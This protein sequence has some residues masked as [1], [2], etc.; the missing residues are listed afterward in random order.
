MTPPPDSLKARREALL[1]AWAHARVEDKRLPPEP[2]ED[3]PSPALEALI[4]LGQRV[5]FLEEHW[6]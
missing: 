5:A 1:N 3:I 2:P 6:S 4:A